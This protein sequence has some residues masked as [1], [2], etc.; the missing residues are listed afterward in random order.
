MSVWVETPEVLSKIKAIVEHAEKTENLN[1][2]GK[3]RPPGEDARHVY[4]DANLGWRF[5]FSHTAAKGKVYRHLS[6]SINKPGKLPNP[7]IVFE[8]AKHFGID[9]ER[10]PKPQV[11]VAGGVVVVVQALA[12]EKKA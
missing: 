10:Q 2:P 8:I 3:T 12:G 6:V 1:Y 7:I 9:R 4:Q 11:D 5:V